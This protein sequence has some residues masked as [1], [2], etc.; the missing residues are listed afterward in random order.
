MSLDVNILKFI[1]ENF[2]HPI[3]D[4]I[5][6][7]ITSLGEGGAIW[8]AAAILLLLFEKTRRIGAITIFSLI[9]CG[10]L[11][12]IVIKNIVQRARPFVDN[13]FI[14]LIINKPNSYSFPSGHTAMS[15]AAVGVWVRFTKNKLYRLIF[16]ILA[17]FMAFSRLY[18]MVHYPTDVLAGIVVGTFS[19]YIA[20]RFFNFR[21]K[22]V[23]KI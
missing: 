21:D 9:L 15:F 11:N 12:E 7:F 23:N 8:F 4:K 5:A 19:A 6:I 17:L 16:I 10:L 18:L 1:S 13:E 22:E 2:H 20:Y 3:L 14:N